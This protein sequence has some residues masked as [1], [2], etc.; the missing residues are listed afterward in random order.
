MPNTIQLPYLGKHVEPQPKAERVRTIEI[1]M[2]DL[3]D[4]EL[5]NLSTLDDPA[6]IFIRKVEHLAELLGCSEQKA[7]RLLLA[8]LAA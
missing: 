7:E 5:R 6:D 1:S 4:N 8:R 3:R 2:A